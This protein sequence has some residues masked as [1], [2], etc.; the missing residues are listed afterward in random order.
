MLIIFI[1]VISVWL[2]RNTFFVI[3][4][5]GESMSP[6]LRNGDLV[7]VSRFCV[8]RK[9]RKDCVVVIKGPPLS[10]ELKLSINQILYIKRVA[11]LPFDTISVPSQAYYFTDSLVKEKA[12]IIL[13]QH[14]IPARHIFVVGDNIEYSIDSRDW[15][16]IPIES[17]Q[18]I[19]V[20][21]LRSGV[22]KN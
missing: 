8:S 19:V 15:G 21:K 6:Y 20:H 9:L 17:V 16:A 3:T 12:D 5:Q 2:L 13:S 18:G 1:V 4:V 22:R 14:D 10:N 11:G 7:L